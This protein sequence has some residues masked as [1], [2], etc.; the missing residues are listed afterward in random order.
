M[1]PIPFTPAQLTAIDPAQR[2]LDACVVAG[3]GSGKTTVLVEY[4]RQLVGAG[5]D[6]LRILAIT[7]TEKA[8]GNMRKKLA[9]AFQS[10]P[11]TRAQ[12]ERAWVSTVHGF[13]ARL[14]RENAIFAGVDPEFRT[15]DATESWRMQQDAMR[16]AIDALFSDHR[17]AM[18][19]LI[20]GL[21]SFDFEQAVLS[22]YDTMRGAGCGVD[23]LPAFP[24][25]A[26]VTLDE[27]ND[28]L[29]AIR[30][31]SLAAWNSAQN[32]HLE[33][34]LESAE[35]IL[36]AATPLA[37]LR[38]IASFACNL[39][40]C[41]RGNNAYN[42]LKRMKE[43]I[44]EAQYGLITAL[45]AP[46]RELLIEILRRF[47][48]LYREGKQQAAALDFADLEEFTVRLL[49][50]HPDTRARLRRQ[51]EHILMDEF[52]DTNPQQARL[53]ELIRPPDRFYAVGD[54][55]QSIFGFRH[56]E[57]AGFTAYRDDVAARGRRLVQ[58]VDNFRSRAHI[59]RAVETVTAG[60]P[61]I[62]DRALVAGRLFHDAPAYSVEVI[63]APDP[64]I[65][66]Q[67]VAHRILDFHDFAFHD[68]AVL[69]RNTEVIPEF[70]AAFDAAGIPYVVN[71]GRGFYDSREVNDLTH[72]LRVI[73]NP[74]DEV[75]LAVVLRSP[76]VD[77]SEEALLR[78]KMNADSLDTALGDMGSRTTAAAFGPQ[79]HAR[80]AR[81]AARLREWRQ[82]REYVTFD[83]LLLSAI[84][85]CGYPSSPNLDKF[86]AQARA[87]SAR[88]S[89]DEFVA[90]LALV[91]QENP[92]EP[93]APPEDSANA[94]QIM[95]V[96]SA[97]GLE[98]PVVFVAAI[99]KGVDT[100]VPVV[101]FS[102]H[103]GLGA[104]WRNPAAGPDTNGAKD[105]LFQH[106]LRHEWS[107][108]EEQ[109]SSRLLYV[110]MTRAE[111]HLV[112]SFSVTGRKPA[113]WDKLVIERLQLDPSAPSDGLKDYQTPDGRPWKARIHIVGQASWP[114]PFPP[115]PIARPREVAPPL[116][117]SPS[118]VGEQHDGNATVTDLSLFATCPRKYYLSRYLG[119]DGRLPKSSEAAPASGASAPAPALSAAGLGTQVHA[120]LAG[121]PVPDATPEALRLVEVFRQSPLARRAA[122]ASRVARE[123]DFLMAVE[124][125]VISG[126]VDLWFE[127][128][129]ELIVVDY[130][131]DDVS[132]AEAH[133]RARDYALQLRLYALAVERVA[134]R[135]PDRACLHFLRPNT[136][137]E[138]DLAPNLIES[139]EQTVRDFQNA[140]SN[141]NF[142]LNEADHCH[143]CPFYRDLCWGQT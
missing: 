3:P 133:H 99:H 131:T 82:R 88:M 138:V 44:E 143:R 121:S 103:H 7:F 35:R 84:D 9:Q 102:R 30:N 31:Q 4:F 69:V 43:Q 75:S 29:N 86:L 23:Q 123:F 66:A 64:T 5:V 26:G 100:S 65:E 45:Y 22:A 124:D 40:K 109:E 60:A 13:C 41:K 12:L 68:F 98:F 125:L 2:H 17:E 114:V 57:P 92:R 19:G 14:L 1:T 33:A 61:G 11:E 56:A 20:R 97:K 116:E 36:S 91:R 28:T 46:E 51:F 78:L 96:H 142:P 94:V 128:G 113:N 53:I 81:F 110:A 74:R 101:A 27:I 67:C 55:N 108:R 104:R 127:E 85:D 34:A 8:A 122:R 134:G 21:S 129:G 135:A 24:T 39:T 18:R 63:A 25:P 32:E 90:E 71:R 50:D 37:A 130:K 106:A 118:V 115:H 47:D 119:F 10:Q 48:R 49:Q 95:T 93:D 73:A 15:L 80:L 83:R 59:L 136:L 16:A 87:S 52:Q 6:P 79:D 140:Q 132:A 42:L 89:L 72:L 120:L 137:V 139:P 70:T 111:C 107:R 126:Q 54:I 105:D 117:L 77:A 58:L 62:E 141:L 112:L 76:L 38:A